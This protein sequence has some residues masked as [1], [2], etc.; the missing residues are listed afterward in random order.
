MKQMF[1]KY[2][3]LWE[4]IGVALILGVGLVSKFVPT[5]LYIIVGAAFIVLGLFRLIP[6]FR[7]T[8]DK[9]LKWIYVA[10][11][12]IDIVIGV[13]LIVIAINEN[14]LNNFL[15]YLVGGVLYLRA[16]VY[17][18]STVLRKESSDWLQFVVHIGLITVG[19]VII[20]KGGFSAE[21]LGWVILVIS[22]IA[23]VYIGYSGYNNYRNYR[24]EYAAKQITK[25]IKKEEVVET[26]T[27]A[28]IIDSPK[29][30]NETNIN[31]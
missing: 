17:F 2:L 30:E 1:R 16:L 15:G 20:T 6:L 14:D 7:T 18:F 12:V 10:E 23:A 26:P 22:L 9:L 5:V 29:K 3:W 27:S 24:N 19:T 8:E 25:R 21:Q 31:A 11:I 4:F 28:E 13:I